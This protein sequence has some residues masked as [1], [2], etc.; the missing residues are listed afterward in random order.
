MKIILRTQVYSHVTIATDP[1]N[2][3][4]VFAAVKHT[5]LSGIM[6]EIF[7]TGSDYLQ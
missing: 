5:I 1:D 7:S 6:E 3:R 2:V 4:F